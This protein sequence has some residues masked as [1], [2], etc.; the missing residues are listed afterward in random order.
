[1]TIHRDAWGT[2]HV[3]GATD[4]AAAFGF[5]YAQA[6]D[7]FRQIEENVYRSIGRA[8]EVHG[9]ETL[10]DD[11]LN[12]SLR[13]EPLA[14]AE[15]EQAGPRVRALLDGYAA[16]LNHYLATHPEVE[17]R[18]LERFEPWYPL[19]MIRYLY[20]QRGFLGAAGLE[21]AEIEAAV[22]ASGGIDVASTGFG[23]P[24]TLP[25]SERGSNS[26]A[27]APERSASGNA[28]LLIN[29]HLPF[30]GPSQVYEGHLLS[31]EGWNFS[32]YGRLGF[33]MPYVGFNEHLAWAS[34]DNA[35]DLVDLYAERFDDPD[36]PLAY[37]YGDGH[38]QATEEVAEIG[39]R[40]G[41][42]V[43]PRGFTLRR[44]HHGPVVALRD[45]RA[46]TVRMAK[47]EEPGWLDQWYAMSRATDLSSFR[48]AVEPLD[49]L[50]GNYLYADREGHIFY[51]YNAAVP[52]RSEAFDWSQ[53]VDGSDP[54][55]EWRGYHPMEDLPQV[56]DPPTGWL[57]NCNG[58][59]FLS[60]AE[61]SD[62]NPDP[63]DFPSY[64]VPEGDN[65]RSR[66]ARRILNV[67]HLFGFD[68]W[69][70]LAYDRYSLTAEE[71]IPGLV[72][73][74]RELGRSDPERAAA[75]REPVELLRD[76]DRVSTVESEAMTLFV[77]WFE[78]RHRQGDGPAGAPRDLRALEAAMAHLEEGWGTWRVPWGEINRLQ[79]VASNGEGFDDDAP[80]LP[81]AGVPSW[82]GSVFTMWSSEVDGQRRRYG[83]GGNSYVA[84]VELGPEVDARSLLVFG[85]S[86]VRG[87]LHRLDQAERYLEGDFKPAWLTLDDVRAHAERS[88]RP[89]EE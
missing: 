15:Y 30:F 55:T 41:E 20:F 37:R 18:L 42:E 51:V 33:P 31:D 84:V 60:T 78:S 17:P 63:A 29:P 45:G 12:R 89:G 26:W 49:M 43:E 82:A 24:P 34:T 87:S 76:W 54:E 11:W 57:Q 47:L 56:L 28:L 5:A 38:R 81:S 69:R 70:E 39:L 35:A 75:L 86:A 62:A 52:V 4:A 73:A 21:A 53:P 36:D 19:A 50:F 83:V 61:G 64:L 88:Y 58:T 23:M 79:R 22:E 7:N 65:A 9:E 72:E 3:H 48:A 80:S 71:E 44:T 6:E 8:S 66:N 40:S 46:L 2:P 16:G 25:R 67:R 59:P 85:P 74:W 1:V 77:H 10:V 13:I 32:G 14:V 68:E 27:V